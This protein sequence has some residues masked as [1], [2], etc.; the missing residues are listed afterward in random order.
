MSTADDL[1]PVWAEMRAVLADA[2]H[3][4]TYEV[5]A[6]TEVPDGY[7]GTTTTE[8]VVETGRC[9][10]DLSGRLGSEAIRGGVPTATSTY[11]A[12][13]PIDSVVDETDTLR[14][15]GREFAVI[16]VARGGLHEIFTTVGLEES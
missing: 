4:D 6:T 13:L 14:I 1:T 16:S 8:E 7:G 10:L 5:I 3:A 12:E 11:T 9:V 15:N 2:F